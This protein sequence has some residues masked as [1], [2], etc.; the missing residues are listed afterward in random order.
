MGVDPAVLT[1]LEESL[2]LSPNNFVLRLHLVDLGW[3]RVV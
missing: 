3:G 1:A 2:V